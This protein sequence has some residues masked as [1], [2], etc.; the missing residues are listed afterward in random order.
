TA[1][2]RCVRGGRGGVDGA[3]VLTRR[4]I[5]GGRSARGEALADSLMLIGAAGVFASLFLT[6]SHQVPASVWATPS[7]SPALR[8]V[9]R[10]PTAWQVYS[11][12]DVLLALLAAALLAVAV[13]GGSRRGRAAVLV[14]VGVALAFTVHAH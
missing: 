8:G 13:V 5:L 11:I 1:R 3:E 9:P 12:A 6:W 7:G 10:D 14:A 4:S 2:L